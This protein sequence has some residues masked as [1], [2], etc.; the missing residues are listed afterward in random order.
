MLIVTLAVGNAKAQPSRDFP[1]SVT[2][3]IEGVRYEAFDLGGF[4]RLLELDASL[5]ACRTARTLLEANVRSLEHANMALHNAL[6]T[7]QSDYEQLQAERHRLHSRWLEENRKRLEAENATS[8]GGVVGW[9]LATIFAVTSLSLGVVY[10][11][12][13]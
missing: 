6:T 13:R 9:V 1:T 8:I 2:T 7:A 12:S 3:Y 5:V 11:V 10:G 4:T